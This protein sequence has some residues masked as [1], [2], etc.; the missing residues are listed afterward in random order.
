MRG[1]P[2]RT[3]GVALPQLGL[4]RVNWVRI[5]VEPTGA[6]CQVVGIAHRRPVARTVPLRTA[7]ALVAAGVP[8]VVH[9]VP[10]PASA[11]GSNGNR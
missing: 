9:R 3:G 5:V 10:A 4:E 6:R 2:Q 8:R 1:H 7:A 11:N